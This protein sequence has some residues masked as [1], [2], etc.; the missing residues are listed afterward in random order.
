VS[1][2]ER[3]PPA[4]ELIEMAKDEVADRYASDENVAAHLELRGM[5]G[6]NLSSVN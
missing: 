4:G 1:G 6:R 5:I 2:P 3:L